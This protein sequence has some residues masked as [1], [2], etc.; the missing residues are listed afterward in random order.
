MITDLKLQGTASLVGVAI[1][2]GLSSQYVCTDLLHLLFGLRHNVGTK[3]GS[4]AGLRPTQ[5][6]TTRTLKVP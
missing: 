1:L 4:L 3:Y 2:M 6:S 5:G